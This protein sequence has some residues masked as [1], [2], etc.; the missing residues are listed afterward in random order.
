MV[1]RTPSPFTHLFCFE[2]DS[3]VGSGAR[4][5]V[6]TQVLVDAAQGERRTGVLRLLPLALAFAIAMCVP[7]GN[8]INQETPLPA[9]SSATI[10]HK[11][12]GI[13]SSSNIL[14]VHGRGQNDHKDFTLAIYFLR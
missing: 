3:G 13:R 12:A 2:T 14:D 1:L 5:F 7:H 9:E 6:V 8:T 11:Q 4:W 10:T